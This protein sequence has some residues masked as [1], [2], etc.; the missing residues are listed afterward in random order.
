M[1]SHKRI[2]TK[3]SIKEINLDLFYVS[4]KLFNEN[5]Y[6]L[7]EILYNSFRQQNLDSPNKEVNHE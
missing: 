4:D 7:S 1:K 6:E 3:W 2:R 5:L